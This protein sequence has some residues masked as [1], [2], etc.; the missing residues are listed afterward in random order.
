[1]TTLYRPYCTLAEVKAHCGI[2]DTTVSYDDD[3]K[4]AINKMSRVIDSLTGR[5]FYKKT[6]TDEYLAG[7]KDY[8][9]WRIIKNE[10][11]GLLCT[12]QLAPIIDV[13]S[14]YEDDVLLVENTDYFVNKEEGIIERA[15]TDWDEEPRAIKIT[16]NLGYSSVDTATPSSDIPGEILVYAVELAAR[17][18]GHFKKAIKNY[19]S[20]A[21]ET[22]DLFGIPKEI[23]K[24]L[25]DMRPVIIG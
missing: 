11:G 7:T 19:V 10:N 12:P 9:G 1:M 17:K 21:A 5:Y 4:D 14:I 3:I 23:E 22:V 13:T 20:G 16:C 18:S 24:A 15:S 8:Q 2:A 6:Y 25:R